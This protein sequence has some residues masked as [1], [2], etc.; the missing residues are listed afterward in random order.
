MQKDSLIVYKPKND[1]VDYFN[2]NFIRKFNIDTDKMM[3]Y[4]KN[5]EVFFNEIFMDVGTSA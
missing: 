1:T 2:S 5:E 3:N 4:L